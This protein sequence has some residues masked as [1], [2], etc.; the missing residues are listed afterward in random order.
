M[1]CTKCGKENQEGTNFCRYCGNPMQKDM[2]A[3][4]ERA[5]KNDQSAISEIYWCSSTELYRVVKVL[6]RDDDTVNDIL[7]DTYIKAFAR[8]D[9]LQDPE[10]LIPW[11]KV[12]ANNTA[13]DWLKKKKPVL[14]SEMSDQE[15]TDGLSFVE[16]RESTDTDVNPEMAMDEKE[17]RRLVMEILN[18][19]PEDQR[20]VVGM[21]YYEEMPV[22]DIAETLGVSENTVKSRLVYARKKIKEQVLE[23]EK[24][25]TKL[26]TVAPFVFFLYL[27][28]RLEN[29]STEVSEQ[30]AL[31]NIL[32]SGIHSVTGNT[33][34]FSSGDEGR[35]AVEKGTKTVTG[36]S[37]SAAGKTVSKAVAG[38]AA[39]T[40]AKHVG[41]KVAS[42]ILA[43]AV[44]AGGIG[45]GIVKNADKLPF[46]QSNMTVVHKDDTK[47]V[48]ESDAEKSAE[49]ESDVNENASAYVDDDVSA[50]P[51]QIAEIFSE[52]KTEGSAQTES[53]DNSET[54][55]ASQETGESAGTVLGGIYS[56]NIQWSL[57]AQG[58]LTVNGTGAIP[59][60]STEIPSW[61]KYADQIKEIV[62]G[63]GITRIGDDAFSGYGYVSNIT[64][65]DTVTEIGARAFM[66]F[67]PR[68]ADPGVELTVTL[69][70]S[71]EKIEE[72]A[73]EHANITSLVL[74]DSL[75]VIEYRAFRR[76]YLLKDLTIG[77]GSQLESIGA[78]VFG[79]LETENEQIHIPSTLK[80]LKSE[81]FGAG[82]YE[83]SVLF[84]EQLQELGLGAFSSS[85]TGMQTIYFT[86]N[87][88]AITDDRIAKD[89]DATVFPDTTLH[90]Y[91][92]AGNSTWDGFDF[93]KL[94]KNITIESYDPNSTELT[95][96]LE[97]KSD[98]SDLTQTDELAV[99]REFYE[100][101]IT[102]EAL[103]PVKDGTVDAYDYNNGYDKDMLLGAYMQDFG[104]DGTQ[105]LL[106]I[107]TLGSPAEERMDDQ[108][109]T[110]RKLSAE[111]YGIDGQQVT[112]KQSLEMSGSDL[113]STAAYVKEQIAVQKKDDSYY[114]YRY[115]MQHASAGSGEF[116]DTFIKITDNE[117]IQENN[118]DYLFGGSYGWCKI[119]DTDYYTGNQDAD[120]AQLNA[121][122]S[123]YGVQAF[124]EWNIPLI[125]GVNREEKNDGQLHWDVTF[126]IQNCFA[127]ADETGTEN[128]QETNASVMESGYY[129]AVLN[130][131]SDSS[132]HG[133]IRG[134]E[135]DESSIT[136][137]GTF[138]K[139]ESDDFA[140]YELLP[141]GTYTFELTPQTE[142]CGWEQDEKYPWSKEDA[143]R[144][145]QRLNGLGVRLKVTGGKIE[146]MS[147]GS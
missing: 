34:S 57:N 26:Y 24:Q 110:V 86:G 128:Q 77:D 42:L 101:Y 21:F 15:E 25:G 123:Q 2:Y 33:I 22:K 82:N 131:N 54:E 102:N 5:K 97:K 49:Q 142:Y 89:E 90:V 105:E 36:V 85:A 29:T 143:L 124:D 1:I 108:P 76:C 51:A 121:S 14:F 50:D 119:N 92:P 134:V 66:G 125:T 41:I 27:L 147:F 127:S 98:Q 69:S 73:F 72:S 13:K 3:L 38:T 118:M 111:L 37:D 99:Y 59:D 144:T 138:S 140:T 61:S 45:Y 103:D 79:D 120:I 146:E 8:L 58:T 84:S 28:R 6:V 55:A 4:I 18:Q 43:G 16:S 65:A 109:Q 31:Q 136:F 117:L 88:P 35:T 104:G 114:L 74:P 100:K 62:I 130:P 17:V 11:L 78:E 9:Q 94:G 19:L 10:R 80:V 93:S 133:V 47:Q 95:A 53:E 40:A 141:D 145:C 115:G 32:E 67:M 48:Q 60:V 107:R 12:I 139:S 63:D 91:Y 70:K 132:T 56:D 129:S 135:Y 83:D 96:S 23:L 64:M 30:Q 75:K 81:A 44:G 20:M 52:E 116:F 71:L 68:T 7:Q 112:L 126:T 122:L 137:Y 113:N 87:A 46:G 106:L 39:K